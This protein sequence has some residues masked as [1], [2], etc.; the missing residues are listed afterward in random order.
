MSISTGSVLITGG[1]GFIGSHT[2]VQ[3]IEAGYEVIL[4]DNFSNSHP[5]VINR[6]CRITG[7]D[8]VCVK[9]DLLNKPLLDSL[10]RQYE[11]A[12]VIHFAGLKSVPESIR[13]PWLYYQQNVQ[14]S[15]NLLQSMQEHGC[16]N[17]VFS[18]SAAV[19]GDLKEGAVTET[20]LVEP[21]SPYG[22]SK[23]MVE[24][25]LQDMAAADERWKVSVLRYFN[26]VGAHPGGSIG[27]CPQGEAANLF[28]VIAQVVLGERDRLNIYGGQYAT[29][30]GT[31]V[32]DYI[33]VM[34]LADGHIKALQHLSNGCRIYN[35]GTG[36]GYS[37]L[38]VVA[39]FEQVTGCE[40]RHEIVAAREGD[41]GCLFASTH[42]SELELKWKAK[43]G[44]PRMVEDLWRWRQKNPTG[45]RSVE[46]E[47]SALTVRC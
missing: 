2:S 6:L 40:I 39:A 32:R 29:R 1:A 45:Y 38:D 9:G 34:D 20:S 42:Q 24:L 22:R 44:L 27:E 41:I 7:R 19:Y 26:P 23:H 16:Y 35:L 17:L 3:L 13:K 14:G 37:V 10:F 43:L 4:L 11:I 46:R 8:I 12:G 15:L 36:R 21:I 5:E 25:M 47:I 28:P 18:S 33:H 30:D 31:G